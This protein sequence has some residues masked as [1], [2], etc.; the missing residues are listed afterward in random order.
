MKKLA[1]TTLLILILFS[2]TAYA[3]NLKGNFKR[4]YGEAKSC[5]NVLSGPSE[6]FTGTVI[7][8]GNHDGLVVDTN[9]GPVTIYGIGPEGY[10]EAN[11][12]DRPEIGDLVKVV[13]YAV[14]F[15]DGTRYAASSITIESDT[16]Q[17]RDTETGCPLWRGARNR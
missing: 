2:F 3:G 1:V 4:G 6:T 12:L 16:L 8:I 17:L 10:W 13:A 14:L 11:S 9:N 7:G 15:S 5:S